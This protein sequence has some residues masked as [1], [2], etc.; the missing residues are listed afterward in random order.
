MKY[1]TTLAIVACTLFAGC[2]KEEGGSG[3][4]DSAA[5]GA[6]PTVVE[7]VEVVEVKHPLPGDPVAGMI[8]YNRI[9]VA[10]HQA[11]GS[12]M[13]GMLAADFVKEKSRLAKTN[14]ELL[15]S[16]R[17]GIITDSRVMPP[18]KDALSEKEMADAL[19]YVRKT[20][21]D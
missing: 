9:C 2:G 5:A 11:D 6:P 13:N 10:C 4:D 21:G 7:V 1:H 17:N 15:E 19:S 20:F 18:Q 3:A 16:I 14:E 12:G 8:V